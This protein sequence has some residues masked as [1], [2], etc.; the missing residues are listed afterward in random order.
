MRQG[1][2]SSVGI[3]SL[4]GLV[5][6]GSNSGVGGA[7]MSANFLTGPETHLS[8]CTIVTGSLSPEV[9]RPGLG[10]DGEFPSRGRGYRKSREAIF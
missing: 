9:K 6:P 4:C 3:G 5:C 2:D 7:K 8:S 10:V 1:R